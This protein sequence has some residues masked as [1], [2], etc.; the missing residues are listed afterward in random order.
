MI[1]ATTVICHAAS[2]RG[3]SRREWSGRSLR[4]WKP[5]TGSHLQRS[6]M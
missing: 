4:D 1:A 3:E 2:G 5:P 6:Q